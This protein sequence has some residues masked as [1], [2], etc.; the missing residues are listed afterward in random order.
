VYRQIVLVCCVFALFTAPFAAAQE[1]Q[2]LDGIAAVVND[3]IVLESDVEEQ[4]YLFIMNAQIRPDSAEVDTLRRQVLDQLIEERLIVAEA[5]RQGLQVSDNE[6]EAE[7]GRAIE[8]A[9]KR[10]GGEAAFQ[11]Q[12]TRENTT[13][14]RLREKYRT[15][16]TRQML[17]QRLVQKTIP[18][19]QVT[20]AEA[21]AYFKEHRAEFP[22]APVELTLQVVQ[23]PATPESSAVAAGRKKIEAI[24]KRITGGEKFAKVAAETSE[25][26][27]SARAGGDLGFFG[28]GVMDETI[29][30]EAFSLP[31]N[32]LSDPIRSP[33][34]WHLLEVLDKDTLKTIA[35]R[36]SFDTLGNLAV[37]VHARHILVRVPVSE[38]DA[39]RA[40][41]LAEKVRKEAL[42]GADFAALA[43][44]YSHYE[45]PQNAKGEIGPVSVGALQPHIRA[46]LESLPVGAIS[47]VLLNQVGYN[48]FRIVDRTPEREYAIEEIREELPA[49]VSQMKFRER[50]Q[51]WVEG[52][53]KKAHIEIRVS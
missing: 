53:R 24:R 25:D 26:P 13:E 18:S 29:E 44:R 7:V 20:Q 14:A 38:A 12:L 33:F 9:K 47:E 34:G 3:D 22:R 46:G 8:D 48:V 4:L 6:I 40:R 1:G 23:I 42:A 17:A 15:D 30:A 32:R 21:E 36:D 5:K 19:R 35:G 43:K 37:E 39:E 52:L 51:E 50:Y 41:V 27:G 2:R 10:L 31:L 49:A 45:G 28:K 16:L 11:E